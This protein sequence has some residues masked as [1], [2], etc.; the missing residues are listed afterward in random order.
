VIVGLNEAEPD[1]RAY[2][3]RD[4]QVAEAELNVV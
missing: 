3:I 4:G 2:T 1:V